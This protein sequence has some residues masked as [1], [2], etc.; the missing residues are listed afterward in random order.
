MLKGRRVKGDVKLWVCTSRHV[1]NQALTYVNMIEAA[2][3]RVFCDTCAVVT[4]IKRLG[5]ETLMTNSAKTAYYAPTLN[6]V[7]VL[8]STLEECILRACGEL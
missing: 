8:F 7:A 3:G 4:W 1:M 2:G 5:V 6:N